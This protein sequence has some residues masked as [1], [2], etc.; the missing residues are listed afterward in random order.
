MKDNTILAIL[1]AFLVSYIALVVAVV[2]TSNPPAPNVEEIQLK[3]G[4][5]CAAHYRGGITC[6]WHANKE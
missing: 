3:D 6:D 5:R 2:T 4:T 1:V